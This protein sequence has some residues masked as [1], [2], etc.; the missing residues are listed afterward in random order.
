MKTKKTVSD[1]RV[2]Q[3][4]TKRVEMLTPVDTIKQAVTL[5]LDCELTTIPIVDS[6]SRCVGILSRNDLTEMF[7]QEDDELSRVLE[8]DRLSLGWLNRSLDTGDTR[9]VKELMTCD[10][11]TAQANQTLAEACQIMTRHKIH[12]LPV[13]DEEG[14]VV[15]I[16]S[17]FDVVVAVAET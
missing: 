1:V 3:V 16:I 5:M 4:M 12:H 7:L 8:T 6:Q 10:V 9:T 14:V 15:G 13:V 11:V 2:N 17:A